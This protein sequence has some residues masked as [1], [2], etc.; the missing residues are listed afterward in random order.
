MN[1]LK[2]VKV[3]REEVEACVLQFVDDT[4]L[5]CE[6]SYS[7]AFSIK[8]F[9]RCYEIASGLKVN[10]H[11]S[12]LAGI[13]VEKSVIDLYAKSLNC[14]LIRLPFK[15]LWV[16]IG[17]NPRKK[18]FSEPIIN[19]LCDKLGAWKGRFL[20]LAWRMCLIKLVL[21]TIPLFYLS[22]FKV[23]TVVY[24]MIISIQRSFL[25]A[26]AEKKEEPYLGLVGRVFANLW[27]K[28]G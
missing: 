15:Y 1:L 21:T 5:L 10:F 16:E 8:A 28:V 18:Q 22:F 17:G 13:N 19:K 26:G 3:G 12:K 24:N 14:N 6:D 11:K 9:F 7:N 4:F 27:R 23:L 2:G 20:S 25:W